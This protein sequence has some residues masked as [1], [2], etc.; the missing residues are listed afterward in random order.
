M[1][2][3]SSW[4][5]ISF[6]LVLLLSF[7][8]FL[9]NATPL[10][11]ADP[12]EHPSG[13]MLHAPK[14]FFGAHSGMSFPQATGDIFNVSI[15]DLTLGKRDFRAPVYG[16]DFGVYIR[17]HFAVVGSFDYARTTTDSEYRHFAEDN[18]NSIRQ[19]T[20]FSQ[21]SLLGTVRYYPRKTGEI[22][23][24]YSW[25]PTRIMP[26]AAA[27]TGIAHY[28]F[29]QQGDFVKFNQKT[30]LYDINTDKLISQNP[31]WVTHVS[32]GVDFVI[33][34]HILLNVEGRYSWAKG[35]ISTG[36]TSY[37]PDYLFDSINL[38]GLKA[39][40]GIYFRF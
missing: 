34:S 37:G 3:T 4:R 38:N 22:I 33:T 19:T 15:R 26:Y 32:A 11:A 10:K 18:G 16:L 5:S 27:G 6:L 1:T 9:L 24:S 31:A 20:C 29:S 2:P 12:G 14:V 7:I 28:N 39:I 35:D 40:G 21:W 36:L 30:L 13:F 25:I 8:I 23:G 17:S